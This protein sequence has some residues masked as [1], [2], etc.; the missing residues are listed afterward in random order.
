MNMKIKHMAVKSHLWTTHPQAS[1][2]VSFQPKPYIGMR[3]MNGRENSCSK[4][5]HLFITPLTMLSIIQTIWSQKWI[6]KKKLQ[7]MGKLSWS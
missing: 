1:R 5:M 2:K 6:I 3:F 4:W 7:N